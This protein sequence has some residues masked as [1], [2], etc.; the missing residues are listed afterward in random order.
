MAFEYL[1]VEPCDLSL[2]GTSAACYCGVWFAGS[3]AEAGEDIVVD[4]VVVVVTRVMTASR[5][6]AYNTQKRRSV[7]GLRVQL[8]LTTNTLWLMVSGSRRHQCDD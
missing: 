3:T 5:D 6:Y 2:S 7:L 4:V 1:S 8:P